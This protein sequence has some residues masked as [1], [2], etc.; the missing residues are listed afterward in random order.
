MT[1]HAETRSHN[2]MYGHSSSKALRAKERGEKKAA[3]PVMAAKSRHRMELANLAV[4][5]RREV[6]KLEADFEREKLHEPIARGGDKSGDVRRKKLAEKHDAE[7][8]KLLD[9]H[10]REIEDIAKKNPVA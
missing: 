9:R 3:D 10:R 2:L 8:E 4:G 1:T 6:T 7:R 5:H